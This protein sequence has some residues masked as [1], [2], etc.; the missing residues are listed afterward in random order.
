MTTRRKSPS[1]PQAQPGEA[2]ELR[3]TLADLA[4]LSELPAAWIGASLESIADSAAETLMTMLGLDLVFIRGAGTRAGERFAVAR[5][6]S[7]AVPPAKVQLLERALEPWLESDTKAAPPLVNPLGSGTLHTTFVRHGKLENDGVL[8]A[9]AARRDFPTERD[10]I[11][12]RVAANDMAV[13]LQ[14]TRANVAAKESDA[15]FRDLADTAP[16]MIWMS[17]PGGT[18]TFH[19]EAWL[20][21]TGQA[22][23]QSRDAGWLE[24]IHPADR[25]RIQTAWAVDRQSPRDT[26]SE[27]RL[28]RS[29]GTYRWVVDSASPR[30]DEHGAFQGYIGTVVDIHDRR[31]AEDELDANRRRYQ[32]VTELVPQLLWI[33]DNQG[34]PIWFNQRWYE[35]TGMPPGETQI[36][37]SVTFPEDRERVWAAWKEAVAAGSGYECEFR[38]LKRD[39]SAEWFLAQGCP[40]RDTSGSIVEWYGSLTNI[41]AQRR[42]RERERRQA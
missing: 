22:P 21:F 6:K 42:S 12:I 33:C 36:M 14:R 2:E 25:A 5:R 9:G 13:A 28:R 41:D 7:S 10:R 1:S 20:R 4:S 40:L 29:D 34:R 26:M 11:V 18:V 38:L 24:A 32:A 37:S 3:R 19:S 16:I 39:G 17:D 15:R 8:F 31:T 35:Y 27:Y 30:F 23:D